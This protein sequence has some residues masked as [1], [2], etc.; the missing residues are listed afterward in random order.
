MSLVPVSAQQD[1]IFS[2][3]VCVCVERKETRDL[4]NANISCLQEQPLISRALSATNCDKLLSVP[5]YVIFAL[6]VALPLRDVVCSCE[7]GV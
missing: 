4:S 7:T 3:C 5:S 6:C 2:F 1:L